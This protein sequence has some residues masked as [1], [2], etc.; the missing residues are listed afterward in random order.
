MG[1]TVILKNVF[2]SFYFN[3]TLHTPTHFLEHRYN[4]QQ[5]QEETLMCMQ[6]LIVTLAN[7]FNLK[8][9]SSEMKQKKT[10]MI[11]LTKALGR[12]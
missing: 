8:S 6:H 10:M 7:T 1:E 11:F 12:F 3:S 9:Q 4:I 2:Y 5:I